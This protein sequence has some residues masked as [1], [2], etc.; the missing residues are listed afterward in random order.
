MG[1]NIQHWLKNILICN[2]WLNIKTNLYRNGYKYNI[3]E[4][5]NLHG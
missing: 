5:E 4:N 1:K 2:D 3:Y